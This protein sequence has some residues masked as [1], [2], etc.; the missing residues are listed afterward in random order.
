MTQAPTHTPTKH[1]HH[2]KR[3][4]SADMSAS[5]ILPD[6]L[7]LE[8]EKEARSRNHQGAEFTTGSSSSTSPLPNHTHNTP[9]QSPR[10]PTI[11]NHAHRSSE[12][13]FSSPHP[14]HRATQQQ[15][16]H[17][18][19]VVARSTSHLPSSPYQPPLTN[20]SHSKTLASSLSSSLIPVPEPPHHKTIDNKVRET[21]QNKRK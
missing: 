4:I 1:I 17:T 16:Q 11:T 3:T 12:S 7:E 20:N 15:T 18:N 21:E 19:S 14:S 9:P 5:S 10:S 13:H 8:P 6:L 2:H